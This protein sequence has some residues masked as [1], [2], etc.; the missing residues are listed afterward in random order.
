[1]PREADKTRTPSA[2]SGQFAAAAPYNFDERLKDAQM[3]FGV[4]AQGPG[5]EA[6]LASSAHSGGLANSTSTANF[7]RNSALTNSGVASG[8]TFGAHSGAFGGHQ[9]T[10]SNRGDYL[11]ALA[12]SFQGVDEDD[13][14]DSSLALPADNR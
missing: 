8:P 14:R 7:L 13:A 1:M 3:R 6:S 2:N 5:R 11:I 4:G 10:N 9:S 12:G